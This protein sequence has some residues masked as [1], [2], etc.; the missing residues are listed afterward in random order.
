MAAADSPPKEQAVATDVAETGSGLSEQ[1][2]ILKH[3]QEIEKLATERSGALTSSDSKASSSEDVPEVP[4]TSGSLSKVVGEVETDNII[5][6]QEKQQELLATQAQEQKETEELAAAGESKYG[7]AREN[8]SAT[9]ALLH[10]IT[11]EESIVQAEHQDCQDTVPK[12]AEA[13]VLGD[14]LSYKGQMKSLVEDTEADQNLKALETPAV[15]EQQSEDQF[16]SKSSMKSLLDET[17]MDQ[18]L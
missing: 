3:Q 6:N 11:T 1:D 10:D 2:K 7:S 15:H 8:D 14:H 12:T 13:D 17:V 4:E 9:K 18:H 16:A 5:D